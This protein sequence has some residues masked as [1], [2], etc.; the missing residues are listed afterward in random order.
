MPVIPELRSVEA[1]ELSVQGYFELYNKYQASQ[2]C[3]GRS[4]LNKQ[5][6][7]HEKQIRKVG[8]R[9]PHHRASPQSPEFLAPSSLTF[10]Q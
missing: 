1:G 8:K 2:C 10:V 7:K 6:H 5:T 3:I 4:Y 9:D